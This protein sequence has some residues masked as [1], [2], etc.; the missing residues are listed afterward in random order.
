MLISRHSTL[1]ECYPPAGFCTGYFL[2]VASSSPVARVLNGH[3]QVPEINESEARV[4][5]FH[6]R[7]IMRAH[8]RVTQID[9]IARQN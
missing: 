4:Q 1:F 9:V 2:I 7:E 3:T 8:I 6:D 5:A